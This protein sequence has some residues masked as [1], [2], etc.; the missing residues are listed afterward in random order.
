MKIKD[1]RDETVH[2]ISLNYKENP[3]LEGQN[4][5]S[6]EIIPLVD[7][8]YVENG[9]ERKKKLI[10][11]MPGESSIFFEDQDNKYDANGKIRKFNEPFVLTKGV[12]TFSKKETL[13]L[14]Y[15]RATNRNIADPKELELN[16]KK[17][18][19]HRMADVRAMFKERGREEE[20]KT[21]IEADKEELRLRNL[22]YSMSPLELEAYALALG[23]TNA[24]QKLTEEVRRDLAILAKTNPEKFKEGM[25]D[26]NMKR[27]VFVIHALKAG[28]IEY[29]ERTRKI[30]WQNGNEIVAVPP[31]ADPADYLVSLSSEGK[32]A[33]IFAGIKK[34][35]Q[36]GVIDKREESHQ[37]PQDKTFD[38][39]E[40]ENLFTRATEKGII[41]GFNSPPFLCSLYESNKFKNF[42]RGK[43]QAIPFILNSP[44]LQK[45]IINRLDNGV[46]GTKPRTE[47]GQFQAKLSESNA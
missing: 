27:K 21:F 43:K 41:T 26:I 38:E 35:V 17:V 22:V 25:E 40:A 44:E 13:A 6:A 32:Y 28:F 4:F 11:Y 39:E 20:A 15:L 37:P 14:D 10:R 9:K 2:F 19:I 12:M 3:S 7:E 24:D 31:T 36:S 33:E 5:P 29:D 42:A 30:S 8:V 34:M 1:L 47:G 23:D 18:T 45:E 16:G 46:K